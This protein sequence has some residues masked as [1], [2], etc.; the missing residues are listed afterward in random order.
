M[1]LA[2]HCAEVEALARDGRLE[3]GRARWPQVTSEFG[4]VQRALRELGCGVT[5]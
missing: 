2:Q 5:S 4:R 1:A 3:E